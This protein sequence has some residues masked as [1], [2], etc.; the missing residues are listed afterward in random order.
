MSAIDPDNPVVKLCVAGVQAE[1]A[2]DSEGAAVLYRQAWEARTDDLEASMA[3]HYVARAHA[4]LAD[5]L[6][7]NAVALEH[8]LAAGAA[9][10]AFLPSLHL[11]VG[12]AQEDA[13]ELAGAAAS[14]EHA[15]ASLVGLEQGLAASLQ[16][17]IDRARKRVASALQTGAGHASAPRTSPP[18]AEG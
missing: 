1:A 18:A 4:D 6:R 16:P 7:W 3:A 15:S 8:A 5:R 2:G 12:S 10:A 11:N 9:A 17:A 14:Y 13:G